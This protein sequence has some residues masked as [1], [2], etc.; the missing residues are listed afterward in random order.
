MATSPNGLSDTQ[1][2]GSGYGLTSDQIAAAKG[3]TPAA[4]DSS[5][6]PAT[7]PTTGNQTDA[8][9]KALGGTYFDP[10]T[11]APVKPF[12]PAPIPNPV[13]A[14]TNPNSSTFTPP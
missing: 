12:T 6:P 2:Q 1:I 9:N 13:P 11:G 10:K 4:S 3:G 14:P 8:V 5:T 7:P